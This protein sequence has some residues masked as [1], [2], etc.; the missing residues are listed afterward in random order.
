MHTDPNRMPTFDPERADP[1]LLRQLADV[2][3]HPW[4]TYSDLTPAQSLATMAESCA[5]AMPIL[6]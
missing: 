4:G 1:E 6:L 5:E 2:L 3:S